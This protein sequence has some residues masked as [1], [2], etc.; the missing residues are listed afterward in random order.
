MKV[1]VDYEN[2]LKSNFP[3]L[4]TGHIFS[5]QKDAE[6]ALKDSKSRLFLLHDTKKKVFRNA[7]KPHEIRSF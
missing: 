2:L 3:L 4:S 6:Q 5:F 1:L 7:E